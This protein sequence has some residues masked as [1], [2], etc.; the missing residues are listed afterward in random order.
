MNHHWKFKEF[1]YKSTK[2]KAQLGKTAGVGQSPLAPHNVLPGHIYTFVRG[3]WCSRTNSISTHPKRYNSPRPSPLP[4]GRTSTN[5][6]GELCKWFTLCGAHLG[7]RAAS[8]RDPQA[9]PLRG[10]HLL[11]DRN[12]L[13]TISS[14]NSTSQLTIALFLVATL[15]ERGVRVLLVNERGD[16]NLST[17]FTVQGC[18]EAQAVA[19]SPCCEEKWVKG[20][21]S[22]WSQVCK[23][24]WN[25]AHF[26]RLF[27]P[28][29]AGKGGAFPPIGE[30]DPIL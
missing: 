26:Q 6:S 24:A 17:Q 13:S 20:T 19:V 12:S 23:T 3:K 10:H 29:S 1:L 21:C 22:N 4:G 9:S 30:N 14:H 8:Y 18:G 11:G 25:W 16:R 7:R 15:L 2:T 28:I 27:R 5:P